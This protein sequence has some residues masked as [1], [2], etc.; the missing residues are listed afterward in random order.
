MLSHVQQREDLR[1]PEHAN[2]EG[3]IEGAAYAVADAL[4]AERMVRP[5]YPVGTKDKAISL[6]VQSL[7]AQAVKVVKQIETPYLPD[8]IMRRPGQILQAPTAKRT[9]DPRNEQ[10]AARKRKTEAA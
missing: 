7:A 5:L 9:C 1:I 2:L 10:P 8:P 3:L 4:S 6:R